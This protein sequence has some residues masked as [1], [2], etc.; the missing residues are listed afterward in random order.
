MYTVA[1]V[2]GQSFESRSWCAAS[3]WPTLEVCSKEV[4][5]RLR[6]WNHVGSRLASAFAQCSEDESD[7]AWPACDAPSSVIVS[8]AGDAEPQPLWPAPRGTRTCLCAG[9]VL[10][11]CG[12]YG[13]L[14]TESAIEHPCAGK[15]GGRIY[16]HQCDVASGVSL[17]EG[18]KVVFYLYVDNQGLGAE[19]CQLQAWEED[20]FAK[21]ATPS[22][23]ANAPVFVPSEVAAVQQPLSRFASGWAC[24]PKPAP[25]QPMLAQH[26]NAFAL[27]EAYLSDF[28]DDDSSDSEV[29]FFTGIQAGGDGDGDVES[30]GEHGDTGDEVFGPRWQ[31]DLLAIPRRHRAAR[32]PQGRKAKARSSGSSSTS[33]PSDSDVGAMPLPPPPGLCHPSF[34]PPPGLSLDAPPGLRISS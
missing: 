4:A 13:W 20:I 14:T 1:P 31:G 21:Q 17:V 34:R 32:R 8:E 33:V 12:H 15:N 30:N 11:M 10:F 29:D 22:M 16:V 5:P 19:E 27:N 24:P 2:T 23:N 6:P 9:E 3:E 7:A 25:V 26:L 18:D 28:T